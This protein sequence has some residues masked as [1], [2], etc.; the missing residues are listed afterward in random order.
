VPSFRTAAVAPDGASF[1]LYCD[2][3][4]AN[5]DKRKHIVRLYETATGGLLES[6]GHESLWD[7]PVLAIR[8]DNGM[9][10]VSNGRKVTLYDIKSGDETVLA[11]PS[12]PPKSRSAPG[13]KGVTACYFPEVVDGLAFSPHGKLLL[14]SGTYDTLTLFDTENASQVTRESIIGHFR[15]CGIVFEPGGEGFLLLGHNLSKK[16]QL[17]DFPELQ[18]RTTPHKYYGS[19]RIYFA[20]DGKYFVSICENYQF[21][22]FDAQSGEVIKTLRHNYPIND[23]VFLRDGSQMITADNKN[24]IR[25]W[26]TKT[27][28]VNKTFSDHESMVAPFRL[29][30]QERY[31]YSGD[32]NGKVLLWEL[33]SFEKLHEFC[34][35]PQR[36]HTICA[37]AVHESRLVVTTNAAT[38]EVFDLESMERIGILEVKPRPECPKVHYT[39]GIAYSPDGRILAVASKDGIIYLWDSNSLERLGVIQGRG[40]HPLIEFSPRGNYILSSSLDGLRVYDISTGELVFVY[41]ESAVTNVGKIAQ[42][43]GVLTLTMGTAGYTAKTIEIYLDPLDF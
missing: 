22:V 3:N 14:A 31:L 8:Q 4:D 38:A 21:R 16:V 9:L 5:E 32:G 33:G 35:S 43:D 41:D 2:P 11:L 12:R 15:T 39:K 36:N 19:G 7:S 24:K 34:I 25:V 23:I 40:Y 1:L 26:D 27:W 42:E 13:K 30:T 37:I 10:A 20:P 17:Y 29:D 18:P 28:Q 6:F